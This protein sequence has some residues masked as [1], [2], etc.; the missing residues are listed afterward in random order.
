MVIRGGDRPTGEDAQD[1][2]AWLQRLDGGPEVHEVRLLVC[3]RHGEDAPTWHYVEADAT[4]GV[5]RRR[6]IACAH[7][8][9]VLDSDERWT[10]PPMWACPGCGHSIVEV[11]AGVSAPGGERASWVAVGVR[12]TEC[13]RLAG[14]TDLV[15]DLPLDDALA[16]L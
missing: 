15:V 3:D 4:E 8:V 10:H 16:G 7:V 11:A 9:G 13:G 2:L 12:C 14:V 6:C 1:L 5:V